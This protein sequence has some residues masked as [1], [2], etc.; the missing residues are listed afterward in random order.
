MALRVCK[1]RE[2]LYPVTAKMLADDGS[3]SVVNVSFKVKYKLLS[4]QELREKMNVR[5]DLTDDIDSLREMIRK[6]SD[7]AELEKYDAWLSSHVTGWEDIDGED[8]TPMPFTPENYAAVMNIISV[9]TAIDSGL[10]KASQEEPV[11][12][13]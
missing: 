10:I 9:A 11:K 8:G 12:N 7:P 3:G 5:M 13:S 2:V 4:R 1:D 6:Q